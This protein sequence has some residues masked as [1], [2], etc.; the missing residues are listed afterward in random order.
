[1]IS[2]GAKRSGINVEASL[3][4]TRWELAKGISLEAWAEHRQTLD[5]RKP[6]R[7]FEC[8]VTTETG[9]EIWISSSGEPTYDDEGVFAGYHGTARDQT[10]RHRAENILRNQ[11]E[12]LNQMVEH[13]TADLQKALES[14]QQLQQELERSSREHQAFHDRMNI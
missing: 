11:T 14:S 1:M 4:R 8:A 2:S 7:D 13:K 3:G 6:F 9:D 5:A 12:V 10:P